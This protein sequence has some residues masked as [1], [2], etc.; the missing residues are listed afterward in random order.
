LR[1]KGAL[2]EVYEG[3]R[4][5]EILFGALQILGHRSGRRTVTV[6]SSSAKSTSVETLEYPNVGKYGIV[7][8]SFEPVILVTDSRPNFGEPSV[9]LS[10]S[11]V[12]NQA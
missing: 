11:S 10:A 5:Y 1:E 4:A 9:L 8:V 2:K 12:K 6:E 3:G 7:A